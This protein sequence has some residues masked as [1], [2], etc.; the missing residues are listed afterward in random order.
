MLYVAIV[1]HLSDVDQ[2]SSQ[3]SC[4]VFRQSLAYQCLKRCFY[5]VH[6]VAGP[7]DP[8]GEIV[9]AGTSSHFVYVR[10]TPKSKPCTTV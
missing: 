6:G 5:R 9:E 3:G 2:L 10:L 7:C 8:S 4:F 1:I